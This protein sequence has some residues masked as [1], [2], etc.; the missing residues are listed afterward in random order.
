M[1]DPQKCVCAGTCSN[2]PNAIEQA[3]CKE[4]EKHNPPPINNRQ[5]STT[6]TLEPHYVFR[7]TDSIVPPSHPNAGIGG[8]ADVERSSDI[9]GYYNIDRES[10][11]GNDHDFKARNITMS[12]SL[13][14]AVLGGRSMA[15]LRNRYMAHI[16][17]SRP[18]T[19]SHQLG[20]YS[21]KHPSMA[22]TWPQRTYVSGRKTQQQQQQQQPVVRSD[23]TLPGQTL[24][25]VQKIKGFVS[26]YKTG[27]K[28]LLS[29]SRAVSG[30][31]TRM[32]AGQ[33][34]TREELQIERRNS[35][36]KLRLVPFG[37]LVVVIPEL[38][39]LTIW[40][41]PG[42]CPSTCVTYSQVVKMARKQDQRRQ[43]IHP[44]ALERIKSFGLRPD[45]FAH[46]ADISS[47]ATRHP[48]ADILFFER[49]SHEDVRLLNEFIGVQIKRSDGGATASLKRHLEYLRLDDRLL[50]KEG[51]VDRLPL[52]ELHRAC[53]DRG[54]PSAD[55]SEAHLRAALRAWLLLA[56]D[57]KTADSAM[58]PIL[59]SRLV[60]FQN[61]AKMQ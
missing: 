6:S 18:V 4:R 23:P 3:K 56:S 51:L 58:L 34:I 26:F 8:Y 46:K 28:E 37:F 11:I 45:D 29:N 49:I 55:Y 40:L 25:F 21:L 14:T 31:R 43:Q 15:L 35:R 39:P 36:D 53:Q 32:S 52:T 38:I 5:S 42:V 16:R 10:E 2:P 22:T 44:T 60:L 50:A 61:C 17:V 33:D 54:I 27:L 20:C 30:I 19:R 9:G 7:R 24:T 1:I 47:M 57:T 41:F 12:T 59:W 48:E 13:S